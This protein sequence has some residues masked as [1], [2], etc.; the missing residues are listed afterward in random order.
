VRVG[1]HQGSVQSTL[2]FIIE[3]ET[4]STE[5]RTWELLY[6]DDLV[7]IADSEDKLTDKIRLGKKVLKRRD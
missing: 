4:L 7:L 2:L 5:F 6:A 1:I 3:L